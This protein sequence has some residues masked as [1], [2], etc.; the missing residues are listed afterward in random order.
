VNAPLKPEVPPLEQGDHL[1][2]SE[3]E[4][5]YHAMPWLKKAELI[6]G[7][8]H[9]PSPVRHSFHGLQHAHLIVWLGT[10]AAATP[11]VQVSDNATDR[12]DLDNEPQPDAL[13]L[14]DP[15]CG[16]QAILSDDGYIEQAPELIGEVAAS[17]ASIDLHTKLHV[18]RRNGV[19]EYMVWQVF[20]NTIIWHALRQGIFQPLVAGADGIYRSEVFPGLWL[21]AAALVQGEMQ[22]VLSV[23]NQG[24][25]S[26]EHAAFVQLLASKKKESNP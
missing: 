9:V 10:Y 20:E 6:E 24:L 2:R 12:L 5:R 7:V 1:T 21:D 8:V 23:L 17:S 19:R 22:R 14:I 25:A 18:Y 13:L 11:G 15:A 4:R 3:F 16:G 26:A